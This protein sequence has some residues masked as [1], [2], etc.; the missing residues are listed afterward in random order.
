MTSLSKQIQSQSTK[1]DNFMKSGRLKDCLKGQES[2][3]PRK[4]SSP[5]KMSS[6]SKGTEKILAKK[7]YTSPYSK[8]STKNG[9]GQELKSRNSSNSPSKLHVASTSTGPI[10][11]QVASPGFSGSQTSREKDRP[12][13]REPLG[14]SKSNLKK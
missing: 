2:N 4:I 11:I 14:K 13:K 6:T 1:I 3:K 5:K 9:K 12:A 7:R 10:D 8:N